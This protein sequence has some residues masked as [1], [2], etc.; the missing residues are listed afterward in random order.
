MAYGTNSNGGYSGTIVASPIRPADPL[1]TIATVFSNEVKG[2]LHTYQTTT[3]RNAL[4]VER[5]DWGMLCYVV[6]D[7]KTYQLTYGYNSVTLTD[8]LN[9]KEFSGSGGSGGGEWL[10][11][12]LTVLTTEPGSPTEGQRYLVGRKYSDSISGANWSAQVSLGGGAGFVAQWSSSLSNWSYTT[13]LDGMSVRVDDEDNAIYRYEGNYP[14]GEWQKEK[15]SQVR[16]LSATSSNG[17]SYSAI[18]SPYFNA[19][20]RETVYIVKFATSNTGASA[21]LSINGLA[22][23]PLK[24]TDGVSLSN[25]ITNEL[26]TNYQYFVTYDGTNF[27]LLNPSSSGSGTG[28]SNKYYIDNSETIT[29]PPFTQY[30]IYGNMDIEG[31]LNNYGQVVV[32]NG[33]LTVGGTFNDYGTYSNIY[34]AEIDGLGHTNYVP[35]WKTSYMLT[36]TSS[37]YDDG[38]RV[39]ISAATFSVLNDLVIPSGAVNGYVLTS[40]SNGVATWQQGGVKYTATQSFNANATYSIH[41]NLNTSAIIFNFWDETTGDIIIPS[42]KKTS[43]NTI[44]VMTTATFSNGRV[45]VMS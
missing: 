31:T 39:T 24:K 38:D 23:K 41:H 28:L 32:A 26:T 5:R 13:P 10:N 33:S 1:Q 14:T 12:V 42:V 29:V 27:E 35:R 40:D 37:I 36:A 34:F 20:D 25:I 30:W 18:S 21:S 45:V 15:E 11:S 43:L 4:I 22:H 8:N 19:Y 2:S 16:Y 44:D 17:A 9:W 7:N 6:A 3:E